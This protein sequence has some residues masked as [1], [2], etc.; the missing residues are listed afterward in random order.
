MDKPYVDVKDLANMFGM[1]KPSVLNSISREDFPIPT[2]KLGKKRVADVEV[3]N[4]FFET[5][6]Q[7]GLKQLKAKS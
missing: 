7:I 5:K 2:Y 4:A 1:T 3:L 6:R